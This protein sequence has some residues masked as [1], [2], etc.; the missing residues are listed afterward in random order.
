MT[1]ATE[2]QK[3]ASERFCLAKLSARKMLTSGTSLGGNDYQFT[4]SAGLNIE[5]IFV[6][7]SDG[8]ASS[9][10]FTYSETTL[11]CTSTVDLLAN[12]VI[13]NHNIYITGTTTRY[14]SGISGVD[15]AEWQPLLVKYPSTS[16]SMRN[17]ADGVFTLSDTQLEIITTDRFLQSFMGTNDSFSGCDVKIWVCINDV[18]INKVIYNGSIASV[19]IK[20]GVAAFSVIDAFNKLNDLGMFDSEYEDT[21]TYIGSDLAQYSDSDN[22]AAPITIGKSSPFVLRDKASLHAINPASVQPYHLTEGLKLVKDSPQ[23]IREDTTSSSFF[24]GRFVGTDLKKLTFGSVTRCYRDVRMSS[25][26]DTPNGAKL[27]TIYFYVQC[28]N[29]YGE[30]GDTISTNFGD[31][32]FV[33]DDFYGTKE[34]CWI[35]KVE[36]FTGPD[37]HTYQFA[38]CTQRGLFTAN[39]N[40]QGDGSVL[41]TGVIS[42][43]SLPDNY[44]PSYSVYR[45]YTELRFVIGTSSIASTDDLKKYLD[46]YNGAS[47]QVSPVIVNLGTYAGQTISALYLNIKFDYIPSSYN[48]YKNYYCRFSPNQSMTHANAMKFIIQAAGLSV[49]NASFTQADIDLVADVSVTFPIK[50]NEFSSYLKEAQYLAKSTFSVLRLNEAREVEYEVITNP[51]I[52]ATDSTKDESNILVDSF[53]SEIQYQDIKS[54]IIFKN[55]QYINESALSGSGPSATVISEKARHL[56]NINKSDTYEHCLV[57]I[58]NRKAAIAGYMNEP[59]IEYKSSTAN[60]D[61]ITKIGDVVSLT[62]NSVLNETKTIKALVTEINVGTTQSDIKLNEI[63][64]VP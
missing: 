54:D 64:G 2:A 4:V 8:T 6:Y 46:G 60:E 11:N 48:D 12:T 57:S 22:L 59:T 27:M 47:K 19:I 38:A 50:S 52:A 37:G 51:T 31:Y 7:E 45:D 40:L 18:S 63:R 34:T 28:S 44:Y 39:S 3:S 41:P 53:S 15:D 26:A 24:V 43:P 62:N 49:N 36:P 33:T 61:L 32:G 5:T 58:Q 56:H 1:F 25:V 9:V 42:N 23:V 13:L 55:P 20:N 14:T 35:C 10:S 30:I 21:H 17:I 29:F 16:Q